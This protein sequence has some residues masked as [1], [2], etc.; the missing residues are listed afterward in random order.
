[1]DDADFIQTNSG[2]F[3]A[4]SGSAT[5][6][7]T[8]AGNTILI[9]VSCSTGTP[10]SVAGCTLLT[11]TGSG[12]VA[13]YGKNNVAAGETSY[14]ISITSQ[15]VVWWI[16]EVQG[17]DLSA[18]VDAVTASATT[19]SNAATIS[20][21]T[22]PIASTY[23]GVALALW[24]L[25]HTT[26]GSVCTFS[27][28]TN[29]FEEILDVGLA[30]GTAATSLC[31]GRKFTA[32][33]GTF[34]STATPSVTTGSAAGTGQMVVLTAAGAKKLHRIDAIFGAEI[35]TASGIATTAIQSP[36]DSVA[37]TPAVVTTTPRSGTY[38]LELSSSA[39]AENVAWLASTGIFAIYL[40]TSF[41]TIVF[42]LSVY[43]P[44]SL[45]GADVVLCQVETPSGNHF[46]RYVSASTK[47]GVQV[48]A[49]TQQV[50]ATTVVADTW[51]DL[52]VRAFCA[53]AGTIDWQLD[54][55]AQTQA[56][57]TT[58]TTVTALR[59]GW[60]AAS[61]ATVRY[62]DIVVS[63][64]SGNYPLGDYKIVALKADPAGTLT[65]G[66][67]SAVSTDFNTFTANSTLAA[68]NA[69]TALANID[70]GPPHTQSASSDGFAQVVIRTTAYVEV[71]MEPY[72]AAANGEAIRALRWYF[73]GWA[74][75][76]TAA[77]IG[78][79][80]WDGAVETIVYTAA[81]PNFDNSTTTAQWVARM[82][83]ALSSAVPY[84]WTQAKLD[85]LCARVGFHGSGALAVG[86]HAVYAELA[87]KPGEARTL[88]G[89][90]AGYAADPES[91]GVIDITVD[92]PVGYDIDLEYEEAGSPTTVPVTGGTTHTEPI[93]APDSTVVNRITAYWAPEPDP[94]D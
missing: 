44:T 74:A 50:S 73:P 46:I 38:C 91:E 13:L 42:R 79:R 26:G 63:K 84:L 93:G 32:S 62:D 68:W 12:R 53:A 60:T 22:T 27:G 17:L 31:V 90:L 6:A 66:G 85:A 9:A 4:A 87:V 35:G 75:S 70:E 1:M 59:I 14:L 88:F 16:A 65:I 33:I 25:T 55:A 18:P 28:H 71:P 2:S 37:G 34:E 41:A 80:G 7:A 47:I 19:T 56:T 57:G 21:G 76:A 82:H 83:R 8:T 5:V 69:A 45:P 3:E 54:G 64:V 20:T 24:G 48:N 51:Y 61:T 39:A 72:D 52:D 10:T 11:V 23:N 40:P 77:T 15:R 58:S 81:D 30:N 94:V 86:V 36:F 67:A 89:D 49:G 43:F 92:A 29:G 78:F